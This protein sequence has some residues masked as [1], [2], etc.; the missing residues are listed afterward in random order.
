MYTCIHVHS[1]G[2]YHYLKPEDKNQITAPNFTL[3]LKAS[4]LDTLQGNLGEDSYEGNA[5]EMLG[6]SCKR[7]F[8]NCSRTRSTHMHT[9]YVSWVGCMLGFLR[10]TYAC[11]QNNSYHVWAGSHICCSQQEKFCRC[12]S[13]SM[14]GIMCN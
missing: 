8:T 5:V 7:A 3:I 12:N 1:H 10:C 11:E 14:C 6:K 13:I 9:D 2:S 4:F